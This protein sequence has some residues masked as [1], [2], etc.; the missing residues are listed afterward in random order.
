VNDLIIKH[1]LVVTFFTKGQ[2]GFLDFSYRIKSLANHYRLTVVSSFK[3]TET[4]VIFPNVNYVV[5]NGGKGRLGWLLYLWR[6]GRLIRQQHPKVVVLLHSMASPVALVGGATPSVVYW[7]E[8]PS[9]V[10]PVPT[11]FS[12]IKAMLRSAIRWLMFK[13]ARNASLVMPI[14]EAHQDDLLAHGCDAS[15]LRL[16]Y[17]GVDQTF[18]GVSL[19]NRLKQVDAPLNLIYVGSVQKDRGRDVM[20]EAIALANN[21]NTIARLTIVGASEEQAEYC[22]E[23]VKKLGIENL[24]AIHRRVPGHAIPDF[25]RDA[26]A[27]ICLWEDLPWYRFNPPTKLFEYLVAGLPVLASNIRTHTY[28]VRDGFNGLIFEYDSVALANAIHRLWGMRGDIAIMKIRT[29][30][31]SSQYLWQSIEP[32]FL[33]AIEENER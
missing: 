28:Y 14:G 8:H 22:Y 24:V 23:Y 11:G 10:A 7:N 30:E 31:S 32:G 17:M 1:C 26:D 18:S 33:K 29:K 12:P 13:G 21:E 20:L 2:T 19:T 6:C 15:R 9:H 25:L 4:E 27:G 5:I 16:T 3:L